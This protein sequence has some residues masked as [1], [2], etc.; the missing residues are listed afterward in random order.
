[1]D[2]LDSLTDRDLK[3]AI[4]EEVQE[5]LPQEEESEEILE[6]SVEEQGEEPASSELDL[7]APQT[8]KE[9]NEGVEA[10]KKLLQALSNEDIAAS[11]KDMKINI[12][13]TIG[14]K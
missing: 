4:G 10:L 8:K 1:M 14:E 2:D 9:S 3:L 6:E 12:N 11:L 5:E 7:E 13:I